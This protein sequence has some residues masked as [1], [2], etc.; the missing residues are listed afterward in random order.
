VPVRSENDYEDLLSLWSDLESGIGIILGSPDSIQEF[1]RRVRQ[2]DRWMQALLERDTDLGLYLLFQLTTNSFVG[3][4]ASHALVS[5]VLCHL[6]AL[7]LKL[8]LP[9]RDSLV[10]AAMTMNIAMTALQDQL[11]TQIEKP[12]LA[13]QS[14]IQAHAT[15]GTLMLSRLGVAD[16]QWLDVIR[17]HHDEEADKSR[18]AEPYPAQRLARILRTVD[19][20]SALISPRKSREARSTND[21]VRAIINS[22]AE[23]N[24]N[25]GQAMVNVVGMYPP[26]TYVRLDNLEIAVVASRGNN[27]GM[28][29]LAV[30]MDKSGM[31]VNPPRL[32]D[33]SAAGQGIKAALTASAIPVKP[34]H[35][36]I[37]QLGADAPAQ[38]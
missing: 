36:L 7:E 16:Q 12:D 3:Y 13:Q 15:A 37:L 6:V 24:D 8:S 22:P 33:A 2:Y 21:S 26:G 25:V 11:A 19:R 35:H 31:A 9:E 30:V 20:Y 10:H 5:A 1:E 23:R 27:P 29:L 32:H 4:S 28:P 14:A 38:L 17:M 18:V 34:R